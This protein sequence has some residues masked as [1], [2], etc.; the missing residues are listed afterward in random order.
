MG[1]IIADA[2]STNV[3]LNVLASQRTGLRIC[4]MNARSLKPKID[5]IREIFK[6]C[7][8]DIICVT[9]TWFKTDVVNSAIDLQ[10]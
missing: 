8:F 1:S 10:N 7:I 5:E 4:H 2:S 3:L 6:C 9:E